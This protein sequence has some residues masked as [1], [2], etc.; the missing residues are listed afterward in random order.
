[1]NSS[2]KWGRSCLM[3]IFSIYNIKGGV[4]K[5]TTSVNLAYLSAAEGIHSLI[6]DLDPQGGTSYYLCIKAKIRGGAKDLL[7]ESQL[8]TDHV[9]ATGY[10]NL[11]LMPADISYRHFEQLFDQESKS[12][13][14]LQRL[15]K[16]MDKAYDHIFLDCPPGLSLL[17][18][19]IFKVTDILLVP[20]I[21]TPLS[22]C[23]YNKLVQFLVKHRYEKMRVVPF[24]N[25]VDTD[26]PIH[27]V[28]S[29]NIWDKYS[30]FLRQAIPQT[31]TIETMGVKRCPVFIY[32]KDFAESHAFR[33]LWE[34]IQQRGRRRR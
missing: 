31:S 20:V 15:L 9:R 3:K 21:P 30:I 7:N 28:V 26:N 13:E 27:R 18:E 4:G 17:A 33:S 5:T 34:E 25:M 22:L 6:W 29:K 19:N 32:A 10:P 11:D 2:L 8:V 24:F 12:D 16:P 14:V 23:A 1:M